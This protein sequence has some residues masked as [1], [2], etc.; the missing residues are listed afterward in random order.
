[1]RASTTFLAC[2]LAL[3]AAPALAQSPPGLSKGWTFE[4]RGGEALY[5]H[6]CAACHQPDGAGAVGAGA[7]PA[8]ANNPRLVSAQYVAALVLEGRAGMPA[9]GAMMDDG[10]VADVVAFARARFGGFKDDPLSAAAVK[11]LREEGK[12]P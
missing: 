12:K 6:V 9:V 7:Y 2:G 5:A 1:M 4:E 3:C 8:L 10:Q 11:A